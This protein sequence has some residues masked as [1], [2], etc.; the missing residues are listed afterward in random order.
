MKLSRRKRVARGSKITRGCICEQFA[1]DALELHVPQPPFARSARY[2]WLSDSLRRQANSF[3]RGGPGG[4]F[5]PSTETSVSKKSGA[6]WVAG[7]PIRS[8]GALKGLSWEQGALSVSCSAR[9]SGI[10]P[11]TSCTL[12]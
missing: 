2:G 4:G 10:S 7:A 3:S 12:T 11:R 8:E 6:E 9:G 1:Q 5:L